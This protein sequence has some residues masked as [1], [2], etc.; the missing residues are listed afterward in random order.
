MNRERGISISVNDENIESDSETKMAR[1]EDNDAF[2]GQADLRD[3]L[4][5]CRCN[6]TNEREPAK[7][8]LSDLRHNLNA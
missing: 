7:K 8:G 4:N 3:N 2:G 1:L 5:G 6:K